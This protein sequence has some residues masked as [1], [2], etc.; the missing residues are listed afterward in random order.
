M[1]SFAWLSALFLLASLLVY[2]PE[3]AVDL[4]SLIPV[5]TLWVT[6]EGD[7][8]SVE[9]DRVRGV[10]ADWTSA[11][12]DLEKTATG[13]VFL[14]TV[15]RV[16]VSREA[17]A[18]MD[19]IRGDLRFR[20]AVQLYWLDGVASRELDAFTAAHESPAAIGNGEEIPVIQ[21]KGGRY[22]LG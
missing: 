14:E 16:V 15:D 5:E 17:S 11:M 20:P 4:G 1:R 3:A 13:T 22:R 21:E 12:A 8:V 9:G 10:G 18:C 2:K 19:A 6:L 7:L